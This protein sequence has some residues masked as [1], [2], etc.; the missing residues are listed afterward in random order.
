MSNIEEWKSYEELN[1][2]NKLLEI[3]KNLIQHHK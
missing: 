2:I 1:Y 3:K